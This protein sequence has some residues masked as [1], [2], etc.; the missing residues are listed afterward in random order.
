MVFRKIT[1]IDNFRSRGNGSLVSIVRLGLCVWVE[2]DFSFS[3]FFFFVIVI[4]GVIRCVYLCI[5]I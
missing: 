2:S 3:F 1:T 4:V 5:R